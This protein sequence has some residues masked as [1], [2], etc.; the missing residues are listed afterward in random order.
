MLSSLLINSTPRYLD[1]VLNIDNPY[2]EGMANHIYP[3][4]IRKTCPCNVY[5]PLYPHFYIAKLGYVGVYP[6]FLFLLQNIDCGYSLE[7]PRFKWGSRGYISH[8]HVFMMFRFTS[9]CYS[10]KALLREGLSEPEFYGDLV[11][12]FKKLTG[13]NDFSFR[14][15]HI[16]VM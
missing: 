16:F 14:A 10:L 3:P 7:P 8:G 11:Y 13:T 9:Q 1:D 15:S 4:T 12:K 6:F 5:T 2:F